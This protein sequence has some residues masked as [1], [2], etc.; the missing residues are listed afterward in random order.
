MGILL[1]ADKRSKQDQD[2]MKDS[3][4]AS[5]PLMMVVVV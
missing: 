3:P 4:E 1:A 5:F 2:G